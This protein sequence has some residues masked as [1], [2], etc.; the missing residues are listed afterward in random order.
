M[1]S[2]EKFAANRSNAQRSTGPKTEA[3]K[4]AA[5][6]N[7]TRHGLTG[8]HVVNQGENPEAYEALRR[9]LLEAYQPANALEDTLVEEIAQC[10]WRLQRARAIEAENFNL[11]C[12]GADP[13][14]GFNSGHI[15]F[16]R[17]RRY[18]TTIERAYH[19][20]LQQLERTQAI[21]RKTEPEVGFVSQG[22]EKLKSPPRLIEMTNSE[23]RHLPAD[24]PAHLPQIGIR[25][26]PSSLE[27]SDPAAG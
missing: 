12:A 26:H 20:A 19:R 17:M 27:A 18:M 24:N 2:A 15:Q 4:K 8:K 1:P 23:R 22:P 10:F 9:D 5:S 13:V 11:S 6:R 25:I 16:D 21:R 14:I 3:G 7:A